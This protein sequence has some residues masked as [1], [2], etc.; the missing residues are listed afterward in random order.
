MEVLHPRCAGLDIHKDSVVACAR[1][2]EGARVV[3]HVETFATT[4]ADLERLSAW[5]KSHGVTHAVM[6]ATGVYWK[7]VWAVLCEEMERELALANAAHVKAVPGRKTDVNDATWLADLLAH[8]LIRP[9]FVPPADVQAL[10]DLTRTCKQFIRERSGH[11]QRIDKLLQGANLKLGSVLSDIMGQGGRA[12]LD[13]LA[14]GES[15]PE[16]LADQVRT[17]V[18]AS[19]AALVEALR[20]RL[21]A[22]QRGGLRLHLAQADAIEAAV[23]ELDREVG[24]HLAPFCDDVARLSTMPGLSSVSAS[25]IL[26][27]IGSDM[28]RFPR[29]PTSSPGRGYARGTTRAPAGAARRGSGM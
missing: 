23:A 24:D 8:G 26:S 11:V 6:E 25:A 27:E 17:K 9:S 7:P 5:L 28:S 16:R 15:D 21:G 22:H 4:T 10:R 3:R 13:A 1:I 29:R 14:S 20:G 12:V 2:A 18:H 19:R